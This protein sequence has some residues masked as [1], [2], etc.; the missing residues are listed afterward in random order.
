MIGQLPVLPPELKYL[1]CT[2]TRI[3]V[4]PELPSTLITLEG[5][6]SHLII[7]RLP[8]EP[9]PLY[10]ARWEEWRA[11]SRMAARMKVLKEDIMAAS[12]HPRR[13]EKILTLGGHDALDNWM[14][15]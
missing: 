14:G 9:I 7:P 8:D 1:F 5:D 6:D 2:N 13:I 10:N 11:M 15:C 3:S 12:W 4:L